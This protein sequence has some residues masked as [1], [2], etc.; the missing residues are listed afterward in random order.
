MFLQVPALPQVAHMPRHRTASPDRTATGDATAPRATARHHTART[1]RR[2][3]GVAPSYL[4]GVGSGFDSS[5]LIPKKNKIKN[6]DLENTRD[7]SSPPLRPKTGKCVFLQTVV[8]VLAD[9]GK[10]S[11][12]NALRVLA[13]AYT[14]RGSGV[15]GEPGGLG[16]IYTGRRVRVL[17]VRGA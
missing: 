8:R 7:V 17:A 16:G 2:R 3:K 4:G 5:A 12:S 1:A 11:G 14:N 13:P 9:A 15:Y 10:K 6:Q